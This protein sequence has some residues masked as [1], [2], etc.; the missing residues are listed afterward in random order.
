[1]TFVFVFRASWL[2][3]PTTV[4]V[5]SFFINL[6]L[7]FA[8]N[9]C[10]LKVR[11]KIMKKVVVI[12]GGK[13]E[14]I[15]TKESHTEIKQVNNIEEIP[16]DTDEIVICEKILNH[17]DINLLIYLVQKL[18]IEVVFNPSSYME[19]L[20]ERI[21]GENSFHFLST[22]FG[23]KTDIEEFLIRS[24]DIAGSLVILSVSMPVL[25]LV[26]LLI[27]VFSPGPLL[28]KQERVG[29]DGKVFTLYKFRTMI[30][31]AEKT[32]GPVW[33]TR[34][35]PRIT[36]IGKILRITRLD[37]FPQ[38]FNVLRGDMS[39]VGP[40]PERPYFVKL[41][42]ALRELRLAVRPGLTGLAQIRN[43]YDLKPRHKIKYDYL[44][45]QRRSLL[46]NLYILAKTVP[47][48]FSK[49]GW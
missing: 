7:L 37:E 30:K 9:R 5:L 41:H 4:F 43:F 49:K 16:K 3:F 26:S 42:K 35:D 31:D 34:Y 20:P 38:L 18:K 23:K 46:L 6:V 17:K 32:L 39:L 14:D 27:K 21:N 33:A 11:G 1:M 10:V 13:V 36:K 28:Y 24:L 29:K 47:V 12:G 44:Y 25:I 48:I 45:I 22:F 40:R 2:G 19:L 15:L 8:F